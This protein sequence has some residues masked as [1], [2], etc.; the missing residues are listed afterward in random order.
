M[1]YRLTVTRKSGSK[2]L[3][4]NLTE[5][6]AVNLR[7]RILSAEDVYNFQIRS[8]RISVE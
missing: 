7:E 6:E 2:S 5:Y 4:C 8:A 1:L 3:Y